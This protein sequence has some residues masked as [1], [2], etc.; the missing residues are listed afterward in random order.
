MGKGCVKTKVVVQS[1]GIAIVDAG[2]Y[3][4]FFSHM[5]YHCA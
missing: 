2:V 4:A 5:H 1:C 3:T